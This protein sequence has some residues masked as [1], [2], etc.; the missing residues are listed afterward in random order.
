MLTAVYEIP[1]SSAE[2]VGA[3][4]MGFDTVNLHRLA[5]DARGGPG[6]HTRTVDIGPR[7]GAHT[8]PHFGST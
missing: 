7:P 6:L 1:V 5:V 3:F 8:G 4:N 2:T